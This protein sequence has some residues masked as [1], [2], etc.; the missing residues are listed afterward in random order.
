MK[1]TERF[2]FPLLL[3]AIL[4]VAA[5]VHAAIYD[6]FTGSTIDMDKWTAVGTGFSL[7]DGTYLQYDGTGPYGARLV[8]VTRY[9]SGVFTMAFSD[10]RCSN[11]EPP[12]QGKGSIA[13]F[14]IGT[15][16]G[17]NWVRIER[18]GVAAGGYVEVNWVDPNE[19]NHP[20]HVNWL[21]SA[22]TA[23]FLQLRYDGTSVSFFYRP[24]ATDPW[25]Q[26][27]KSS[28][29]VPVVQNG[30]T[31]PLVLR[32]NWGSAMPLFIIGH[33]GASASDT[34]HFKVDSVD[35]AIIPA[36]PARLRVTP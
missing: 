24:L 25:T 16:A 1:K 15:T 32:P 19:T 26:M 3:G 29:G 20:I 11:N 33:P 2:S 6:H 9:T 18:G 5:T 35:A 30:S 36:P 34:L 7:S 12:N 28:N 14:G 10:Y 17:N 22:V 27:A 23:G 4:L 21:P 8:S 13:A 31:V